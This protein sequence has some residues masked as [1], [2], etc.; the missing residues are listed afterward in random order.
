[1]TDSASK[2][3]EDLL[4]ETKRVRTA[5]WGRTIDGL[6]PTAL[7]VLVAVKVAKTDS[8]TTAGAVA[9]AIGIARPAASTELTKL[10]RDGYVTRG[11]AANGL[12][13][14]PAKPVKIHHLKQVTRLTDLGEAAVTKLVEKSRENDGT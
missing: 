7:Q 11:K 4:A 13:K 3:L 2:T 1:M 14:A 10:A 8:E 6:G 5:F 9:D 12:E